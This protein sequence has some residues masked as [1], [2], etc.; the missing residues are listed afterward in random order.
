VAI[1][2][3]QAA[4]HHPL[5]VVNADH[6]DHDLHATNLAATEKVTE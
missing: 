6:V 1:K 5:N 2:A 3:P 4:V